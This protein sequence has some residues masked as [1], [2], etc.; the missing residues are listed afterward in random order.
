[1][2]RYSLPHGAK[3]IE[4]EGFALAFGPDKVIFSPKPLTDGQP[5]EPQTEMHYT[6]HAGPGSGVMDL[7]ETRI[8]PTGKNTTARCLQCEQTIFR[9]CCNNW[10][11]W[12][13]S[14]SA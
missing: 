8:A 7:H 9:P 12:L 14:C 3:G 4:G 5:A 2:K 11:R 6:F 13:S 1:M 10:S